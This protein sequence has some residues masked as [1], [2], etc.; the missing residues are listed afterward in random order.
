M[1]W[2]GKK[3]PPGA[4]ISDR[5]SQ[6]NGR[7]H[8]SSV[9]NRKRF[10]TEDAG[11]PEN[12]IEFSWDR[13]EKIL[14]LEKKDQRSFFPQ[15]RENPF[16]F[17]RRIR[18]IRDRSF[19]FLK[20]FLPSHEWLGKKILR[21]KKR[22]ILDLSFPLRGIRQIRDCSFPAKERS[23]IFLLPE[24]ERSSIFPSLSHENSM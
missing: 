3:I 18:E 9:E 19:L 6:K 21:N 20:I 5:A 14:D 22:A 15:I 13:E 12:Y 8:S 10:S 7:K 2:V 1:K 16:I 23:S 17:R 24:R 11:S 4:P